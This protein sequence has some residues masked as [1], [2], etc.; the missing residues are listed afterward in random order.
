MICGIGTDIVKI[1]RIRDMLESE[2]GCFDAFFRK[3]F[4]EKEQLEA[5]TRSDESEYYSS[6]FAAK[7]AIFKC[8]PLSTDIKRL[9]NMEVLN[10][11]NGKP[12]VTLYGELKLETEKNCITRI[13]VSISH[14]DKYIIAYA[15]AE[16]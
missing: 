5:K 8:L 11:E 7:E 2:K 1:Q 4:T 15:I 12:F 3:S 14:E 6:R 10:D 13:H 16:K 9:E